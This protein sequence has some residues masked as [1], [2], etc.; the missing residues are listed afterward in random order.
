MTDNEKT[1]AAGRK[2]PAKEFLPLMCVTCA[3]FIFNT[4]EF[5]P[6]GLL[7]DI[8]ADFK[9]TEAGAGRLISV[10]AW[11]VMLL[12]LPLMLLVCRMEMK[13]LMLATLGVFSASQVLS[14]ASTGFAGLMAA[15]IGV[16]CAHSVFWSIASPM[17]VRLVSARFHSR[18]LSLIVAGTSI[19][20]I[21]GLPF[22][23]MIGL[24]VGWRM[25]FFGVGMFGFAVMAC[26]FF[27]TPKLAGG[28][29]FSIG[30]LPALFE[31]PAL[32]G[33]FVLTLAISCAYY[34]AYSYIEPFL[35]QTAKLPDHW[36]TIALS[37][38][39][40][41]GLAGSKLF[42]K[43]YDKEPLRFLN[44]TVAG[45]AGALIL[46]YPA[47]VSLPSAVLLFV[48]WGT[49]VTAFNVSCQAEIIKR[50]DGSASAVAM[51]IFSGIFNMGIASGT[52]LGGTVCT[53]FSIADIGFA[54]AAIAL[55]AA[56][57]CVAVT[58][59]ANAARS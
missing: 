31:T 32:S 33:I 56:F 26:M 39:G 23:R 45:V 34:T 59:K 42:S 50:T 19:A 53:R 21:L 52:M 2:M 11:V 47:S 18:A 30:K 41:S 58:R 49:S 28:K 8:A 14:A 46:L 3:A 38:F 55:P 36:V 43:Y 9:M 24:L 22:G 48:F 17:A 10:Y 7:T 40:A 4:S 5:M 44:L 6:I 51:S 29:P 13:K 54:G 27:V 12:S 20:M 25:T 1:G 37:V 35:L 16:A 15:R 57:A